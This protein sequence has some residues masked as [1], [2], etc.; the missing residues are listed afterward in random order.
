MKLVEIAT[1]VFSKEMISREDMDSIFWA[2]HGKI[3]IHQETEHR[4]DDTLQVIFF[5]FAFLS[6]KCQLCVE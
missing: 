3:E 5:A 2:A 1:E 6:K 4:K